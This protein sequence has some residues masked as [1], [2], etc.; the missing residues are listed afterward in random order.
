MDSGKGEG[1]PSYHDS[2]RLPVKMIPELFK[3]AGYHTS[4]NSGDSHAGRRGKTDYNFLWHRFEYDSAHWL[5]G[6]ED[7][8]FF[9]QFQL[10]GGKN[11]GD[12]SGSVDPEKMILPPYYPNHPERQ[13]DW[14]Q[15]MN[16]WL[17]VDRELGQAIEQLEAAG[18]LENTAI[19]FITDHGVSHLRGKQFLYD[20]GVKVPLIVKLPKGQFA[21]TRRGDFVTQIDVS[22]TSLGLAGIAIPDHLQG[23]DFYAKDYALKDAVY[24]A[25]DRCDETV[26]ILRSVRTKD[27]K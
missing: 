9:A 2:Y 5:D 19:F 20:E 3:E 26:E 25:R 16:S 17:K 21:G 27:F 11:S 18:R 8:P 15:Y 23:Q 24:T 1:S 7:K 12:D 13:E 10:R 6:P 14:A 22:A 4:L